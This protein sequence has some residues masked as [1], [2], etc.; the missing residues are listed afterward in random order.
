MDG[1]LK[2][3]EY[4]NDEVDP[5]DQENI[6]SPY[7]KMF[8]IGT[9]IVLALLIGSYLLVGPVSDILRGQIESN[10]LQG[11]VLQ[12]EGFSILF[13]EETAEELQSLYFAEQNVEFSA[14]LSGEKQ[15]DDYHITSLYQP[16]MHQQSFA[17]VS[18]EP[19]SAGTLVILHTHPY[20]SCLASGTDMKML[21]R[22]KEENPDVL[23]VVM[24]E[25]ARF[26]VYGWE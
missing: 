11:N 15:G 24:C 14:C 25:P 23:M 19:C 21:Q 3:L 7:K 26:S 12:L 2:E 5:D 8:L 9:G 16:A 4:L 1:A 13:E 22:T 17:H 18:F 20:K 10:P 6:P